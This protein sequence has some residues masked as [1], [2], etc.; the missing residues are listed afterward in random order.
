MHKSRRIR[1]TLPGQPGGGA[2]LLATRLPLGLGHAGGAKHDGR[3][4]VEVPGRRAHHA[5]GLFATRT[6]LQLNPY[7]LLYTLSFIWGVECALA[8][9][10]TG[11][12]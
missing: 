8:V 3:G 1:G 5:A 6:K 11:G 10:G 7:N 2:Q 12:P 9:I 4:G